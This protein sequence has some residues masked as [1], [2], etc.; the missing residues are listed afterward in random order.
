MQ[1]SNVQLSTFL[2][3]ISELI[4]LRD[5]FLYFRAHFLMSAERGDSANVRERESK[6]VWSEFQR[7]E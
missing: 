3:A 4:E 6:S 7:V 5:I 1:V 2:S